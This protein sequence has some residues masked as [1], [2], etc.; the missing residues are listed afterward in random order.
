M[1]LSRASRSKS[2]YSALQTGYT[3]P[4]FRDTVGDALCVHNGMY[5]Y[6]SIEVA[7]FERRNL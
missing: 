2:E 4:N 7:F 6:I 5:E 3:A 1:K